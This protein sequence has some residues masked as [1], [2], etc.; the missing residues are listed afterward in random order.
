MILSGATSSSTL[1]SFYNLAD[2]GNDHLRLSLVN[3]MAAAF[4]DDL[5]A[6]G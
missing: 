4:G 1:R 6:V 5:L 3:R 2:S